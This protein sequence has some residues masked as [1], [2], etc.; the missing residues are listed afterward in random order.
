MSQ[1]FGFEERIHL[2]QGI[3]ED[4]PFANDSF[5]RIYSGGCLHHTQIEMTGTEVH[6]VLK[7][8][9]KAS[10]VDPIMT[11]T[12]RIFVR[13]FYEKGIGRV[14]EA[15]CT[16][17]DRKKVREF[18][19]KYK[20]GKLLPYRAF[21]HFPLIMATRYFNINLSISFI[22]KIEE[23]DGALGNIFPWIRNRLS[24]V[25]SLCVEK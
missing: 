23:I 3:A 9:G 21:T 22:K 10:F 18:L 13:P 11:T 4:I 16:P 25:A 7:E 1:R 15:E 5:D 2:I 19:K 14:D 20:A 8:N 24:P 17:L 6:R 12:Y